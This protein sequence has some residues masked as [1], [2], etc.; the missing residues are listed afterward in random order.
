MS[1][2]IGSSNKSNTLLSAG[3]Q[4]TIQNNHKSTLLIQDSPHLC[5]IEECKEGEL[6]IENCLSEFSTEEQKAAALRN[7]GLETI[8]QW[9]KIYGHI[10]DQKDLQELLKSKIDDNIQ[11]KL[12]T[13]QNNFNSKIDKEREG[14]SATRQINYTLSNTDYILNEQF[15]NAVEYFKK[16]DT[17]D[18]LTLND[19]I[20]ILFHALFPIEY[21][22]WTITCSGNIL[23]SDSFEKGT[24]LTLSGD[25]KIGDI[26]FSANPGN[27]Q[28]TAN[29]IFN[30]SLV[31]QNKSSAFNYK[32]TV[33][34][35]DITN[36]FTFTD[37]TTKENTY[38]YKLYTND[39]FEISG[40]VKATLKLNTFQYYYHFSDVN[41]LMDQTV[42]EYSKLTGRSKSNEAG[43]DLKSSKKYIY[44]LS[45][46]EI[47]EVQ[48]AAGLTANA[49][50]D[51]KVT[52]GWSQEKVTYIPA[53]NG[54][55]QTYWLMRL[56]GMQSNYIKIKVK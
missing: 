32:Y 36:S 29:F 44:V 26:T 27:L 8:A 54:T 17:L 12:D 23:K 6:R 50:T 14:L 56:T 33:Y 9:G 28:N 42:F 20:N 41:D 49:A 7:L 45:P 15:K 10:E 35:K 34:V 19:A 13:I 40:S 3:S 25:D 31:H 39:R 52:D 55:R 5:E 46:T 4:H 47:T 16:T 24:T 2:L 37:N 48:T 53:N 1:T 43:H 30:S 11:L 21:K 51:F 18:S 22:N 38:N